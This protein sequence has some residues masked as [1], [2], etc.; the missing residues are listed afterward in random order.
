MSGPPTQDSGH[1]NEGSLLAHAGVEEVRVQK[2]SAVQLPC[3]QAIGV[4][5]CT[6][7]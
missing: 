5:R 6:R 3:S 7:S 2:V 1:L 4:W